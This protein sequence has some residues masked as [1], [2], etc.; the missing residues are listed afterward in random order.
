[1]VERLQVLA[2]TAALSG[3]TTGSQTRLYRASADGII[4]K[5]A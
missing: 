3:L 2:F 1:M 5:P 4:K